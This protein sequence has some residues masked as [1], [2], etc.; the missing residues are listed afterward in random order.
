MCTVIRTSPA[1]L[2]SSL[3]VSPLLVSRNSTFTVSSLL[4]LGLPVMSPVAALIILG[5][6]LAPLSIVGGIVV[7]GSLAAI[8]TRAARIGGGEELPPT[9][10]PQL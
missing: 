1:T 2:L 10:T 6:P 4:M 5:E 3:R 7:V 9:E 8:A